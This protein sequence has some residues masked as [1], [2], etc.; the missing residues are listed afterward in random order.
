MATCLDI[1]ERA[2]RKIGVLS[3]DETLQAH[4]VAEGLGALNMMLFAWKLDAVD[5]SH[6]AKATADTFP[7]AS[8]YEEGAVYVLASRL[9]PDFQAPAAFDADDW[10]RSIQAAYSSLTE[11]T[12]PSAITS[13]P[14]QL[15][16]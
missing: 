14:S 15:L 7:L 12:L 1:I 13:L 8:E 6:S 10:F 11:V 5:T 4:D 3:R 16:G 9:S 2:H